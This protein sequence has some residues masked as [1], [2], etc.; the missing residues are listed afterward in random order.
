MTAVILA[1]LAAGCM[2]ADRPTAGLILVAVAIVA[3]LAS[4][5]L[6]VLYG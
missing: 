2:W 3:F 4:A 6:E 1:A 5:V